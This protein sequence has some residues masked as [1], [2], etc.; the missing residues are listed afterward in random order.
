MVSGIFRLNGISFPDP[1]YCLVVGARSLRLKSDAV[2]YSF[3]ET[4]A[5]PP[6][7]RNGEAAAGHGNDVK[8]YFGTVLHIT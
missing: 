1:A 7:L 4:A 8:L 3:R 6:A 2:V 5:A